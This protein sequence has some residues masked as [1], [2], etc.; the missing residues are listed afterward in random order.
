M[1]F[2][3]T[4]TR[5]YDPEVKHGPYMTLLEH[6]PIIRGFL[7]DDDHV[8]IDSLEELMQF[9]ELVENDIIL[10]NKTRRESCDEPEIEI[11]NWYRE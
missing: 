8:E 4:R 5:S 6:Y 3:V 9:M 11:Y 1:I 7:V 10:L 2:K